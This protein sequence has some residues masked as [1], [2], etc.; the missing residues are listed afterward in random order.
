M[1]TALRLLLGEHN[2]GQMHTDFKEKQKGFK[3]SKIKKAKKF[4]KKESLKKNT[5]LIMS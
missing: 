2:V 3:Y 5:K 1:Y 4:K